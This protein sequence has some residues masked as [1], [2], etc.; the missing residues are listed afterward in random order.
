[1]AI[2]SVKVRC[3]CRTCC[4]PP[5]TKHTVRWHLEDCPASMRRAMGVVDG[6]AG[7]G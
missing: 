3:S 7:L 5:Q 1:M 2:A 6:E 4:V